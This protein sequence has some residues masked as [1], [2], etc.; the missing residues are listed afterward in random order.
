MSL[1]IPLLSVKQVL[2]LM[3]SLKNPVSAFYK[4]SLKTEVFTGHVW[5]ILDINI[6]SDLAACS[7]G[8][9]TLPFEKGKGYSTGRSLIFML[10]L[11]DVSII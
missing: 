7:K 9:F 3:F 8:Q 1:K 4:A 5:D 6:I 11:I 2:I 10:L